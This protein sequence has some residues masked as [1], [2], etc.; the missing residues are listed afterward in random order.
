M[1]E[2]Q[3]A[4]KQ[5]KRTQRNTGAKKAKRS[6]RRQNSDEEEDDTFCLVCMEPFS[7]SKAR[8]KWVQ[9]AT[10]EMWA[11]DACAGQGPYVYICHNC[12]SE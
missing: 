5:E 4:A 1:L 6:R 8:E 11:H 3:K 10:C 2:A 9:C 7:N 12:E